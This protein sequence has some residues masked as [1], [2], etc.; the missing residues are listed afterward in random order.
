M[1]KHDESNVFINF[2]RAD[3]FGGGFVDNLEKALKRD[4]VNVFAD[5]LIDGI[6]DSRIALVVFSSRYTESRRCLDELVKIKEGMEGGKMMVIPIFYKLDI[7]AVKGLE[8]GLNL[9]N[10]AMRDFELE[11]LKIWKEALD[12]VS[13]MMGFQLHKNR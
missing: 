10:P 3:V 12:S 13:C 6:E 4:G 8:G 5:A 11:Q 7:S 2:Y 9:F 1:A